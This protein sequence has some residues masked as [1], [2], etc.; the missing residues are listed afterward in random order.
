MK[1]ED[2]SLGNITELANRGRRRLKKDSRQPGKYPYCGAGGVIEHINTYTHD[3]EYLLLA[4]VGNGLGA[5]KKTAYLMKGKFHAGTNVHVLKLSESVD[6]KYLM[7]FLNWMNLKPFA[8]GV[9]M[10]ALNQV[11][12]KSIPIPVPSLE[13]QGRIVAE[14]EN[15]SEESRWTVMDN[16]F[17]GT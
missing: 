4:A 9:A 15:A 13:D 1:M 7:H 12:L 16:S 2:E 5:K 14:I 17:S 6:S 10:I 11:A 8:R 3:G